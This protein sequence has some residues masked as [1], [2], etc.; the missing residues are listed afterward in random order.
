MYLGIAESTYFNPARPFPNKNPAYALGPSTTAGGPHIAKNLISATETG[1]AFSIV[2]AVVTVSARVGEHYAIRGRRV[3]GGGDGVVKQHPRGPSLGYCDRRTGHSLTRRRCDETGSTQPT[4]TLP[5]G[6]S[7]AEWL[8][9]WTQA[10]KGPG[11]NRSRDAV[12]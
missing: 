9:C 8:V 2:V 10:Q 6:G 12:G 3:C 11:S 5:S 4:R 1:S 7:V